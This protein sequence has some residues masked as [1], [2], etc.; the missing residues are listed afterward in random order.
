[1]K[2]LLPIIISMMLITPAHAWE[3]AERWSVSDTAL[4]IAS[5]G[6]QYLDY[7]QTSGIVDHPDRYREVNGILDEH[8]TQRAVDAFFIITVAARPV[9]AALLPPD[10]EIF[11]FRMYPRTI[12]L[13]VSCGTSAATVV[14]NVNTGLG[15]TGNPN[16]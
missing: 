13:A 3:F 8:P 10:I 14:G 2:R 6:F 1:M 7:R 11:G 15:W 9:I 16:E 4:V 12:F 5:A